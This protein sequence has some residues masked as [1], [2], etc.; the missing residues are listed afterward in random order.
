MSSVIDHSAVV[1]SSTTKV[2]ESL[3]QGDSGAD[4]GKLLKRN[5]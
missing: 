2:L 4:L 3:E 5:P 1:Q